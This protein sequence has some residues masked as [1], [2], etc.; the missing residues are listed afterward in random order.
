M[1]LTKY[2]HSCVRF[3]NGSDVLVIDPGVFSEVR[4]ALVGAEAVLIT[5]EHPDHLNA[6]ALL[7]A[8]RAN[9]AMRV[10]G[11]RAGRGLADRF[12]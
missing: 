7:E 10:V 11:A 9:A 6:P 1:R 5:H 4:P 8:A 2:T 12:R 3:D